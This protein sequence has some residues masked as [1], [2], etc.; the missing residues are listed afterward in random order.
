MPT[1]D[2][3][4]PMGSSGARFGSRDLGTRNRPLTNASNTIGTLTR[5]TAPYQ[6]CPRRNP[7]ATGPMAPAPPLVAAQKAIALVRSCGGNTL[8]RIDNV[9]GMISAAAA[10]I[11][12][13]QAMSWPMVDEAEASAAPIRKIINP[14]CS[15]PLRPNRSPS[16]PVENSRPA[17]TSE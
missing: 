11:S 13:R 4:A 10:P 7:L 15:A 17:K 6:K 5:N 2:S 1:V 8:T 3:T 9:D 16:A 12:A 14:S